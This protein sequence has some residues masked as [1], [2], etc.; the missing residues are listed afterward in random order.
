MCETP[1]PIPNI[2]SIQEMEAG[3]GGGEEEDQEFKVI[4]GNVE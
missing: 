4:V 1:C 3:G 2:A